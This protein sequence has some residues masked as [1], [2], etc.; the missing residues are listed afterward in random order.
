MK[1]IVKEFKEFI[2]RGNVVDMAVGVIMGS[3]FTKIVT[4]LVNDVMMPAI[5][6][7]IGDKS[8]EEFKYVITEATETTAETAVY[9]G[10]FIQNVV[11]F[12]LVAVVVFIMVKLIN[13]LRKKPEPKPAAP[14]GPTDA[15]IT[16][17]LLK[18]NNELLKKLLENK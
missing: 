2:S 7:L 4:S 13:K 14:A 6:I 12:L 10:K 1:G 3:T 9:Y 8:F 11:D 5:G 16:N 15:Q 18:E 17:E